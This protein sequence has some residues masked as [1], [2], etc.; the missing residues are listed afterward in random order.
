MVKE[1]DDEGA[2]SVH[3]LTNEEGK[4][5]SAQNTFT[6]QTENGSAEV[7]FTFNASALE[8]G[9]ELVVFERLT[10]GDSAITTHEDPTDENQ[11]L[12]IVAPEEPPVVPNSEE[13][14]P[15]TDLPGQDSPHSFFAKTGSSLLPW[16]I[17]IAIITLSALALLGIAFY[18]HRQAQAV[19]AAF[20]RNLL[21]IYKEDDSRKEQ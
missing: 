15:T 13:P 2:V 9:S 17:G 7:A 8:P 21:G 10:R 19:T 18:K 3:A 1:I 4:E 12:R 6:P 5:I 16:I 14:E 20:A 11:T